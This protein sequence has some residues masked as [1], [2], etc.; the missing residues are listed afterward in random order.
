M[1][2]VICWA[3]RLDVL[4][5]PVSPLVPGG[6]TGPWGGRRCA[7]LAPVGGDAPQVLDFSHG[8]GGKHF[9]F[10][11]GPARCGVGVGIEPGAAL[12]SRLAG[13]RADADGTS[14]GGQRERSSAG[15]DVTFH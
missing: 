14:G 13:L 1:T 15:N 6:L 9:L 8:G 4:G 2:A 3:R 7:Q 12:G 10:R 5:V 11:V